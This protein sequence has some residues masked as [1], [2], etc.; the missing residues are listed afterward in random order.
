MSSQHNNTTITSKKTA[1]VTWVL[2]TITGKTAFGVNFSRGDITGVRRFQ[3][4]V[5]HHLE[6][7]GRDYIQHQRG[8]QFVGAQISL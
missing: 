6:E 7:T 8:H 1:I 4:E 3:L 2:S 5:E